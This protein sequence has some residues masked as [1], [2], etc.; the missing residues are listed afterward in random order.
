[1]NVGRYLRGEDRHVGTARAKESAPVN[2]IPATMHHDEGAYAQCGECGRYTIDPF[3]LSAR[4][5]ACE[6]GSKH[7]WCGSFKKPGPGAKWSG[8]APNAKEDQRG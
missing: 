5:R 1:M 6:C 2:G 3:S 4:P 7:G 8:D